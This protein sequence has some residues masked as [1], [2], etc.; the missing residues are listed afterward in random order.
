[1]LDRPGLEFSFSG[2]KTAV[3]LV[4]K[5]PDFDPARRADVALGVETAIVATLVAKALR[6]LEATGLDTL[7]VSG[8]VGANRRLRAD[9]SAAAARRGA[10]VVSVP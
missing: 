6:A 5:A 7:V 3:S 9:L 10:R 2:L 1:M 8:G 4:V